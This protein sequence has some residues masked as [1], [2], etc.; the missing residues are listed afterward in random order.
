MRQRFRNELENKILLFSGAMGTELA[1]RGL[2]SGEC[3]VSWNLGNSYAV[4]EVLRLYT[5]AGSGVLKTNTFGANRIRLREFGLEDQAAAINRA[6]IKL[7]RKAGGEN[8]LI[9]ASIGPT[10]KTPGELLFEEAYEAFNE[11][12]RFAAEAGADLILIETMQDVFEAKV[13]AIAARNFDLPVICQL[14][15]EPGG[16]T[17]AGSDAETA[18]VVLQDLVDGLGINCMNPEEML[19]IAEEMARFA[20][21]PLLFQ[22]NAGR[23]EFVG[24]STVYL[25][26]PGEFAAHAERF[27]ALGA[28]LLG[29]C[30]G[31]APEHIRELSGLLRGRKPA[32]PAAESPHSGLVTCAGRAKTVCIGR[33]PVV[34]G[35][36]INPT[37]KKKLSES[38]LS[39]DIGEVVRLACEQSENADILDVNVSVPGSDE[40]K[41][42]GA[43]VRELARL[44]IPLVI[45]SADPAVLEE[46]LRAFPGKA[47]VNSVH[48]RDESLKTILPLARKYN[49]AL[50]CLAID[51]R[52]IPKTAEERLAVLNKIVEAAESFGIKRDS[53]LADT[54]VLS[55]ATSSAGETL[56]A[57]RLARKMG[58]RTVLGVSNVSF[59]LPERKEINKAFMAMALECGLDAAIINPCDED[60]LKTFYAASGLAGRDPGFRNYLGVSGKKNIMETPEE[61]KA[62]SPESRLYQAVLRGLSWDI[63][64]LTDEVLRE[65]EPKTVL[66]KILMPA[67]QET[68]ERFERKEYYLINLL[69]SAEAFQKAA[70][71]VEKKISAMSGETSSRDKIIL[72][73]VRGDIHEIGKNLVCFFL[74][75]NGYDVIDLGKDVEPEKIAETA[76]TE[77]AVAVGLSALMTTTL[78]AMEESVRLL[79]ERTT[80][81]IAVGGAVVNAGYAGSIGADGYARD[82]FGAVKEFGRMLGR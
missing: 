1:G 56:G 25:M 64:R 10:G 24:G 58:L 2:K 16:H 3:P 31:T 55:A 79:K 37:G 62:E 73:S 23:P 4:E 51:E 36:R 7:A 46:G 14:T 71:L 66:E 61:K 74:K 72:A 63:E 38:L 17:L 53:L 44:G 78:P 40:K 80:C 13:A 27:I 41:N 42:M 39:G 45:D 43:A 19:P 47:I 76:L 18:V 60:V 33:I 48:G 32:H 65:T 30:C 12:I 77:K 75:S 70:D 50:I 15:F 6:G 49:A 68:G 35:E 26:S 67:I 34:I 8:I 11:Q 57:L 21:V 82:A 69:T 59:G 9:A 52:G 28:S 22:P 29:G 20:A 81:K 54:L 5:D